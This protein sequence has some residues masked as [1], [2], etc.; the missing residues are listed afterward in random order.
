MTG[1]GSVLVAPLAQQMCNAAPTLS[2][3]LVEER[4][5]WLP[6]A[7]KDLAR[8]CLTVSVNNRPNVTSM[9]MPRLGF[10]EDM[11]PYLQA[12]GCDV[13]CAATTRTDLLG[14]CEGET[15]EEGG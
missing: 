4:Y 7:A 10:A 11:Q 3:A 9:M 5:G 2:Q 1:A 13:L 8:A 12:S 14:L 6:D 15:S